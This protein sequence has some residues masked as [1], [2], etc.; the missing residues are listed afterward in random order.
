GLG[1]LGLGG[2]GQMCLF[3]Y[4][5]GTRFRVGPEAPLSRVGDIATSASDAAVSGA[6]SAPP[7]ADHDPLG[8]STGVFGEHCCDWHKLVAEAA[9]VSSSAVELSALAGDE[10]PGLVG[11]LRAEPLPP[12]GYVS[13]HAPVKGIDA[14]RNHSLLHELPP[15]VRSI[16][17]HPD[18]ELDLDSCR[19]LAGRLTVE[20]HGLP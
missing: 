16:V 17:V 11:Y 10:L 2:R 19:G 13:V 1:K 3:W 20:K 6:S 8:I 7:L 9:G 18:G 15:P 12:F 14:I 4:P 5:L